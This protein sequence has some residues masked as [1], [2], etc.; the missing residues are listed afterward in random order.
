MSPLPPITTTFMSDLPS[1]RPCRGDRNAEPY[2]TSATDQRD[3]LSGPIAPLAPATNTFTVILPRGRPV[4]LLRLRDGDLL[5]V[6]R[7]QHH[8]DQAGLALRGG[9]LRHPVEGPG[10]LVERLARLEH[11]GRL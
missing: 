4:L 6:S 9:V 11:L 8:R 7:V 1:C 10:R 2:S 3:S 5:G